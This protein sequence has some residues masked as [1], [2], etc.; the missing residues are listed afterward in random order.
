LLRKILVNSGLIYKLEV[1]MLS[2][3]F[4][5]IRDNED[6]FGKILAIGGFTMD[7]PRIEVADI[8]K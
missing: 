4:Y 3:L 1:F 5:S 6:T 7:V 8:N 2:A